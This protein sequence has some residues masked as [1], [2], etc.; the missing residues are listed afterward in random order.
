VARKDFAAYSISTAQHVTQ[1]DMTVYLNCISRFGATQGRLGW[2]L[3]STFHL[4]SFAYIKGRTSVPMRAN[5]GSAD[6]LCG[7]FKQFKRRSG[8]ARY[9]GKHVPPQLEMERAFVR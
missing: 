9:A 8:G 1:V 4:Y 5:R 7:E 2:F 6:S 3:V